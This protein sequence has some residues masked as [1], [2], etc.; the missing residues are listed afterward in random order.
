MIDSNG[1][2][3]QVLRTDEPEL[4]SIPGSQPRSERRRRIAREHHSHRPTLEVVLVE[5]DWVVFGPFEIKPWYPSPYLIDQLQHLQASLNP[6]LD[7]SPSDH[8]RSSHPFNPTRS[9]ELAP[10]LKRH[11][12]GR[13]Q[14]KNPIKKRPPRP[15]STQDLGNPAHHHH[16]QS[17]IPLTSPLHSPAVQNPRSIGQ[18]LDSVARPRTRDP[19][20]PSP[21]NP[22]PDSLSSI[23]SSSAHSAPSNLPSNQ[24]HSPSNYY[25][26]PQPHPSSLTSQL[27][28]QPPP[29]TCNKNRQLTRSTPPSSSLKLYVCEGCLKYLSSPNS[30]LQHKIRC[31]VTHPPGRKV[32]QS[33]D[34]IIREVDGS[35][36]KLYCQCL[37]LFGKLFIDHK[38]IFFDVEGFKFY[39]L[40]IEDKG[41]QREDIVGYFSKE[42]ISYD[43]Y[44]LACI[45]TL[46]PYQ[47][48]GYGTL[49]IEFSY[50]L[51]RFEAEVDENRLAS[52]N[53][54]NSY[55]GTP[56]RPLSELGAKGY[57]SF[58]TSVLV[59][60]FRTL[61]RPPPPRIEDELFK[62]HSNSG[63]SPTNPRAQHPSS[64]SMM[65]EITLE[66]IS[67]STRLRPDD[68]AFALISS[69]LTKLRKSVN[70]SPI[71]PHSPSSSLYR[72]SHPSSAESHLPIDQNPT[73]GHQPSICINDV[74]H[75]EVENLVIIITP[76][77]VEQVA[78]DAKVKRAILDP[79][80]VLLNYPNPHDPLGHL[81]PS[82]LELDHPH[83]SSTYLE[84]SDPPDG[85]VTPAQLRSIARRK[86]FTP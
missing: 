49:L 2:E 69:G 59:R 62:D 68:V 14:R 6:N 10:I 58:W 86:T 42:K 47:K 74:Q 85:D 48:K 82:H 1:T 36:A 55:L 37:C 26:S 23:T 67:R 18:S 54:T 50:E 39:V 71:V 38:Y 81:Q 21:R 35:N 28:T 31:R 30:Y 51:D 44:N 80:H 24:T 46:P 19:R 7:R 17:S 72:S 57:L 60:F 25:P 41:A 8:H 15:P 34:L 33:H 79:R 4:E 63:S 29:T 61:F 13:F 9:L 3:D 77:L 70:D 65:I 20:H 84:F 43:G 73:R 53:Y 27:P 52:G 56:E 75:D 22:S 45:V 66:E 12:N 5:I 32:Y 76:E 64:S 40:T 16:H 11:T 78:R 83:P